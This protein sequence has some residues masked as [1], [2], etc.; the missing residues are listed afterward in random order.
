M[1]R[2]V[3]ALAVL[4]AAG[5]A[6]LACGIA[7]PAAETNL[8]ESFLISDENGMRVKGVDE[9][10]LYSHNLMPGDVITRTLTLRNPDQGAPFRLHML[11]DAPRSAG[12]VDWL[13]HL[14]LRITLDGRELYAGRLRGDGKGT[15]TMKGNGVD[16]IRKG[17]DLGVFGKGGH[18]TLRF[19]VTAD[20][21]HMSAEDLFSSSSANI[22]WIFFAAKDAA[23]DSPQTGDAARCSLVVL[24]LA[25]LVLSA[26]FYSRT[27]QMRK[28]K[29]HGGH[30][31]IES[32]SFI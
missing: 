27:R 30:E 29:G 23:P 22:G 20:A 12:S 21:A 31:A 16:L 28:E 24:L 19:V 4:F 1:K 32:K 14:H 3:K 25:L 6:A 26:V 10:F 8:P 5:L 13:D 9:F 18:G 11:G 2:L 17:L 7:A 15:R